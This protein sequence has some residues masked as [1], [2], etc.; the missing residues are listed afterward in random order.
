MAQ[1]AQTKTRTCVTANEV[2]TADEDSHACSAD[3]AHGVGLRA[4]TERDASEKPQYDAFI[5]FRFSESLAESKALKLAL[6]AVPRE[7]KLRVFISDELPGANIEEAVYHALDSCRLVILMA[8]ATYGKKTT[9]FSTY[10]ELNYALNESKAIFLIKMCERWEEAHVRGK[11]G[12]HTVY[13]PWTPGEKMPDDLVDAISRKLDSCTKSEDPA[14]NEV[15][16]STTN[17][18]NSALHVHPPPL[19]HPEPAGA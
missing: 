9:H 8:T 2:C 5:S 13:T 7:P 10:H 18:A 17:R 4:G 19:L 6:E 11:F 1:E 16:I 14:K 12:Q 3:T 15:S